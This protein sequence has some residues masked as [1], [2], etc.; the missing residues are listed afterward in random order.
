MFK[1]I[2][3]FQPISFFTHFFELFNFFSD[4][5]KL[6]I[7]G[8]EIRLRHQDKLQTDLMVQNA[9]IGIVGVAKN[10]LADNWSAAAEVAGAAVG[11]ILENWH[12]KVAIGREISKLETIFAQ[13]QALEVR[14]AEVAQVKALAEE[15]LRANG[16]NLAQ[17]QKEG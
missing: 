6:E 15:F 9:V 1:K 2:F 7:A 16:V 17:L 4:N 5:L 12:T 10:G 3:S 11:N 13:V 14:L 8:Q